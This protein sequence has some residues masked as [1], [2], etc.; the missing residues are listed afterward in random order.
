MEIIRVE[1]ITKSYGSHQV[2]KDLTL[3]VEEGECF[4]LLGPSGCGKTVLLRLIA[5]FEAPDA[6][7]ISIGGAVVTDPAG[8]VYVP[9]DSRGLG[10]VFQDYAVWPHMTVFDNVAYPLKI[11]KRPKGEL[12]ERALETI[13]LVGLKGLEKRLPSELSGGQQQRVALA[14]ALAG[15]PALMLLDEPLTN[16]D[17]NLREEMRFEIKE[18]QRR[19]NIT[20]LYVTHDQE[21]ALAISDRLAIMDEKGRIRQTG[22]PYDIFERS[23]DCFVFNFMGIANFLPVRR[24]GEN[25]LVGGGRQIMPWP[26]PEGSADGWAAGFRP[27]DVRIAP[28]GEGLCGVV[29]RASFLGAMIDYLIEI[30]GAQL[31]TSM[32]THEA[33]AKKMIFKEGDP[34]VISFCDLLWFK[35][36]SLAEAMKK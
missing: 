3:S 35:A 34:C 16:L 26:P 25:Y 2:H 6:G 22:N 32:E 33:I 1:G 10:V 5:G 12:T 23:S 24:E 31:R 36:E 14:R 8:G 30:D 4:T 18:L 29:K 11:A 19:L 7:K 27:S 21:V 15:N 28:G 17:A 20:V 9:P 13:A